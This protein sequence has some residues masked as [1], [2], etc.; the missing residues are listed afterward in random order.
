VFVVAGLLGSL[1]FG[2][3]VSVFGGWLCQCCCCVAC[4]FLSTYVY[5]CVCWGVCVCTGLCLQ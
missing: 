4:V 2:M 5:M 3:C 1:F